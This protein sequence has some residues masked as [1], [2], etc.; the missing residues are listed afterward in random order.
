M[1]GG[2]V[3]LV[4]RIFPEL[5][6]DQLVLV[7][8][9]DST[10]QRRSPHTYQ[11]QQRARPA[12]RSLRQPDTSRGESSQGRIAWAR[13]VMIFYR[14]A[15]PPCM[16]LHW[17]NDF[18]VDFWAAVTSS[19]LRD[20]DAKKGGWL[21]KESRRSKMGRAGGAREEAGQTDQGRRGPPSYASGKSIGS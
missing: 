18:G 3:M 12:R 17:A 4:N 10:P 1:P 6:Q 21:W 16:C 19:L 9:L 14:L 15:R 20:D 11:Q 7:V 2:E 8:Y 5:L 13:R